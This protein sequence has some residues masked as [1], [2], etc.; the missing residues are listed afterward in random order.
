MLMLDHTSWVQW[1]RKL[2]TAWLVALVWTFHVVPLGQGLWL[3]GPTFPPMI[4]IRK[5]P[6]LRNICCHHRY[7]D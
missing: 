1:V 7:P 6:R 4:D 5:A 3:E 2:R